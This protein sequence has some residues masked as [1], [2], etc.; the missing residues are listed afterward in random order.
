MWPD[1]WV[2]CIHVALE[3]HVVYLTFP[4]SHTDNLEYS[5]FHSQADTGWNQHIQITS[6]FPSS[7]M[8]ELRHEPWDMT[9]RHDGRDAQ[10]KPD[11]SAREHKRV[12]RR[13]QASMFLHFYVSIMRQEYW[14]FPYS[15]AALVLLVCLKR[16]VLSLGRDFSMLTGRHG[17]EGNPHFWFQECLCGLRS[18]HS[19]GVTR[20]QIITFIPPQKKNLWSY[21]TVGT[22]LEP[23]TEEPALK[24]RESSLLC[25]QPKYPTE[26][27]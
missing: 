17:Q 24:M 18:K 11:F 5:Y 3:L 2:S 19:R 23:E 15:R 12:W 9:G 27:M 8:S 6:G 4:S 14:L 10:G 13:E 7:K 20:K 25:I 1:R 16:G 26:E 21:A 22:V